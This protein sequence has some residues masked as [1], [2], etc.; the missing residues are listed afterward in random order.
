MKRLWLL[1][2]QTTTVVLAAYFVVLTL[3]PAWLAPRGSGPVALL[4][5][6]ATKIA[7]ILQAPAGQL[8]RVI[9]A[10]SRQA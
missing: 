4:Q 8:A 6:P 9:A 5:A 1:F 10:K 3:K 2:S 7:C